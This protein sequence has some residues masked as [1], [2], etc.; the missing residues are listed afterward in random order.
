MQITKGDFSHGPQPPLAEEEI[1][2]ES[3]HLIAAF[4]FP[5]PPK[6]TRRSANTFESSFSFLAG[7]LLLSTT[8]FCK[9]NLTGDSSVDVEEGDRVTL[10]CR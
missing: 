7:L 6:K 10:E 1:E 5:F 8:A 4:H 3:F 9:Q 2:R